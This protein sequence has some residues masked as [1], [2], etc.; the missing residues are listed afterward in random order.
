MGISNLWKKT[1]EIKAEADAGI[2]QEKLKK[3][4]EKKKESLEKNKSEEVEK[5]R[6]AQF[7]QSQANSKKD[8][9]AYVI[10]NLTNGVNIE[11]IAVLGAE[12]DLKNDRPVLRVKDK[13]ENIIFEEP[14]PDTGADFYF[15]DKDTI[16]KKITECE[17]SLKKLQSGEKKSIDGLYEVDWLEKYKQY[18]AKKTHLLLG[19]QGT[20][21]VNV[22]GV[23]HYTFDIVGFFKIPKFHYTNKSVISIP[24][25]GKLIT[26][27]I[28]TQR[29]KEELNFD[30]D[31]AQKLMNTIYGL[32]I[33]VALLGSI[34]L[35]YQSGKTDAVMAENFNEATKSL[36]SLIN[37]S[38]QMESIK[39]GIHNISQSLAQNLT[40]S[41]P[42]KDLGKVLD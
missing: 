1:K 21:S 41:G 32:L 12:I 20:Y 15:F 25:I 18:Q 6:T 37:Q 24:P 4:V 3:Q 33:A 26:A 7:H 22:G 40:D 19:E 8:Y 27:Q 10:M 11:Q 38:E 36:A 29:L 34:F 28:L 31:N 9:R 13:D 16:D 17:K 42:T 5:L 39:S 14:K 35:L 23:P 2:K 30:K